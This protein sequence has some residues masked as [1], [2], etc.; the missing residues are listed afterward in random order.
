MFFI[1]N[2]TKGVISIPLSGETANLQL[3]PNMN[4]VP[5]D[6]WKKAKELH[7]IKVNIELDRIVE[8]S[9]AEDKATTKDQES[10]KQES[11][12]I[13]ALDLKERKKLI[14]KTVN[15]GLLR[16]WLDGADKDTAD[17]INKQL[18]AI[19]KGKK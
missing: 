19:T 4:S 12:Q 17:A 11:N 15:E 16:S 2:T 7:M 10:E 13:A 1:N 18:A 3:L 9:H 8:E 6:K 5:D 14:R